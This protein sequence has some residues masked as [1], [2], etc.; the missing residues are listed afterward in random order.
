LKVWPDGWRNDVLRVP[1]GGLRY[2]CQDCFVGDILPIRELDLQTADWLTK[3]RERLNLPGELALERPQGV[4]ESLIEV[5]GK[6]YEE[7]KA[8]RTHYL[9]AEAHEKEKT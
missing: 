4:L 7:A 9:V 2:I 8:L 1:P 3:Y 6:L 5:L